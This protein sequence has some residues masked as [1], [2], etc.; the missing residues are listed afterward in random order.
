MVKFL[1][2]N[3]ILMYYAGIIAARKNIL[4]QQLFMGVPPA[5]QATPL[6]TLNPLQWQAGN[7]SNTGATQGC[8]TSITSV[9]I[10]ISTNVVWLVPP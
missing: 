2:T 6:S 1:L 8:S 7:S 3:L 4:E 9:T 5:K 10:G